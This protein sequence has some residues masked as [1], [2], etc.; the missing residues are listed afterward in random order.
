MLQALAALFGAAFTVAACYAAGALLIARVTRDVGTPLKRFEAIPLAFVTGA[1]ALHLLIFATLAL[2]IGYKGV[3]LVLLAALIWAG[4]RVPLAGRGNPL[5]AALRI[6]FGAIFAAF[7]AIYFVNAWAP[8]ISP[9]GSGYHLEFVAQFVRAHRFVR[10][11]NMYAALS[12][13]IE[14]LYVPAFAF[15]RHSAAALV[16]FAFLVALAMA[17]FAYGRRIG[18]PW[19]GAAGALLVYLSPVAGR[20]GTA[21]YNDVAVAAIA[22]GVFYWL[23]IWDERRTARLLIPVGLL[24][25]FGYAAKYTACVLVFYAVGFVAWRARKIRPALLVAGCAAVMIAPWMLKDWVQ[26]R[27]PVAPFANEIFRNSFFHI[28]EVQD[29]SAWLRRYDMANLWTLPM[30]ATVHG[31]KVQGLIGPIFLLAPLTLLALRFR[32]GRRLL[33]PGVLFLAAYFTNIGARFLIPC[34]PFFALAMTLAIESWIPSLSGA[35]AVLALL[36]AAHAFLSWPWNIKLYSN[37][38]A[39]RIQG[40]PFTAAL[41][42][43][44]QEAYLRAHL[45]GDDIVRMVESKVPRDGLVYSSESF[46]TSYTSR[47]TVVGYESAFGNLLR[48]TLSMGFTGDFQPTKADIFHFAERKFRR[49][50]VLQS[51][52]GAYAQMWD[53]DELRFYDR[54]VEVA[55]KPEWKVRAWPNPWDAQLAFDNSEATRWRTW[56]TAGPGNFME[57]DFGERTPI[58]EVEIETSNQSTWPLRL[59]IEAGVGPEGWQ[60]VTGQFQ[61]RMHGF[62]GSIRRQ[63]TYEMHR[64][65]VDYILMMDSTWGAADLR[66]DPE[67]WGLE[68]VGRARFATLYKVLP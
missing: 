8:E 51:A 45:W 13:G 68:A 6:G 3:W 64:R 32:E 22:F 54:G 44:S 41:R 27:N 25:G 34:M 61:V 60:P 35:R 11:D 2:R 4:F 26:Y 10:I 48:D 5:P 46:A 18:K 43:E 49:I 7:T 65:G 1:A 20:D 29:W 19:A 38:Y 59:E 33:V 55:R 30:D 17:M 36:V 21:A 63:A 52:Q 39:W 15:G 16:H 66:D 37:P 57:V 42:I 40:I 62:R 14:T 67:S 50:R 23:E 53:V 47:R 31:A 56:E 9:D 24:A 58:D 12:E 28:Y